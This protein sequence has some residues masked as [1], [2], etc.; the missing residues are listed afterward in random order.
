MLK[1]LSNILKKI[2]H[3]KA[4]HQFTDQYGE[5]YRVEKLDLILKPKINCDKALKKMIFHCN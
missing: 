1:S 3:H 2:F 4:S 5:S